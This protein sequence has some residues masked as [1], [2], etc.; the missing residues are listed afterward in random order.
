MQL[1]IYL[2]LILTVLSVTS[3]S[4]G[5]FGI[6]TG[7]KKLLFIETVIHRWLRVPY[8]LHVTRFQTP[9][10]PHATIVLLHGLGSSARS[11]QP[12]VDKLPGDVRVIG[13][14][15]LGFGK[16]PK[17]EWVSYSIP[18]QARAV[19]KAL[20]KLGLTQRPI[21]VGH[22]MGCLVSIE[23]AK[24]FPLLIQ[25][26]LLCS[27]PLYKDA[28]NKR[29]Q[30]ETLRRLYHEIK[31]YPGQLQRIAPLAA[32]VGILNKAF[33]ITGPIGSVYVAA[34]EAS[35]I[36]QTALEDSRRLFMPVRIIYGTFD[37]VVIG[38]NLKTLAKERQNITT[39]SF[40]VGHEIVG[41][42]ETIVANELQ[43]M[44]RA[45]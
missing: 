21:L 29:S 30:D 12:V 42:Y 28:G 2:L 11:W 31:K 27:P 25:E 26:L 20:L 3:Q 24:R 17:P 4:R 44:M 15:L 19:A 34:L 40:P 32:R 10:K 37:P 36:H 43:E 1:L 41:R 7:V 38:S 16:S 5:V 35:I 39:K 22:S 14:D 6:L 9:K 18:T 33:D 13:I 45:T 23:L 8:N